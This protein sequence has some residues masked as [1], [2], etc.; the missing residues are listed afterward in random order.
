MKNQKKVI[1]GKLKKIALIGTMAMLVLSLVACGKGNG[2]A[3]GQSGESKYP[4]KPVT[5][6]V[7]ASAGGDTDLRARLVARYLE[8][9][10]GQPVVVSN[11]SGGATSVASIKLKESKP[12][13]YTMLFNHNSLLTN[14]LFGTTDFGHEDLTLVASMF[15]VGNGG[16][17]THKNSSAKTF[18][19]VVE[20]LKAQPKSLSYATETGGMSYLYVLALQRELGI[21]FNIVDSG[22]AAQRTSAMMGGHIDLMQS[23]LNNLDEYFK[24]GDFIPLICVNS[25]SDLQI[26]GVPTMTEL[27]YDFEWP[28]S[29]YS[30][31]MPAEVPEE[32][33]KT[34][35]SAMEK[36]S[37]NDAYLKEADD[38]KASPHYMNS[39]NTKAF[40]DEAK[41]VYFS[42]EDI[43]KE[44]IN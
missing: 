35:E 5:L 12:D 38:M 28:D 18:E 2:S 21:E 6:I 39:E 26:D 33:K 41:K 19:Q 25:G 27:G 20:Q 22:D 8:K 42:Y 43:V 3:S 44:S 40:Y 17:V 24:S 1:I 10:L 14:Q 30:I 23:T 16:L 15:R 7:P 11:V 29:V 32:I 13:G 4:E 31:Y 9:E 34:V 36:I 37:E